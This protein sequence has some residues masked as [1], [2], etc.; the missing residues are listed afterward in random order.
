MTIPEIKA[1][2]TNDVLREPPELPYPLVAS[3]KV[4][5]IFDLGDRYLIIA[6]D[7]ISAFDVVLPG[8][9]AGKGIL[10]TQV[11]LWWFEQ[12]RAI[13][14][15][16]LIENQTAALE[17]VLAG[18]P[19]LISRS[20]L[21]HKLRPLRL[22][23]IVRGHLAGSAW[24]T[25]QQ[26]GELW[27]QPLPAGLRESDRL[28]EPLFT[29]TTKAEL[30]GKDVAVTEEQGRTLV[31]DGTFEQLRRLSLQLFEMGSRRARSAGLIL[32]D[33][34][35]EFGTDADGRVVLIDEVFTPDSSRFW[36]VDQFSPG[37]PQEAFDKQFV[38]DYLDGLDWD[39]TDPGPE[40]P[41]S[42]IEKTREKYIEALGRLL[43]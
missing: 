43:G 4:R 3:G 9:I 37:Q 14:P 7:R 12:S 15:N 19:E 31:G 33:T 24:R 40:L 42:I 41:I 38:R 8:G 16:H 2:L 30:G 28:P 25:Y 22:E 21:V 32:A 35:F 13:V 6:S 1:I 18:Q 10:L 17:E 23:A 11:S 5:D 26:T 39:K 27:G 20:M 29:P 34:K 36:S